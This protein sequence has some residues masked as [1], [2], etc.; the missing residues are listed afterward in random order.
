MLRIWSL[1]VLILLLPTVTLAAP[2]GVVHVIDGDTID[3][4][5]VRVRLHGI[6]AVEK[7][8]TCASEQGVV[9]P[10]GTW[11]TEQ[12]ISRYEG[13]AAECEARAIDKYGRVVAVCRVDG[14]DIS[15]ALVADGLATAYRKYSHDYA[16]IEL[17]AATYKVG[18]W[19]MVHQNPSQFR[20]TRAV[21]RIAVNAECNIKGNISGNGHIY[22]VPGQEHYERT[23]I[24]E[25]NGE[26]WF[27]TT[28]EAERAG[29][30]AARR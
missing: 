18:L 14:Q 26:R 27:C 24:R 23:G 17:T 1:F 25:E 9:W 3:V 11:V 16:E 5:D 8:Q 13:R 29:W 22:H 20:K 2:S 6:D 30:R 10:C 15:A 21:G 7:A 4:G 12:V 19:S 28:Q